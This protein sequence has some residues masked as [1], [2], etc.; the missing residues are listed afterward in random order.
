MT[1]MMT[2]EIPEQQNYVVTDVREA[3]GGVTSSNWRRILFANT[4]ATLLV[5][6]LF[7]PASRAQDGPA[8]TSRCTNADDLVSQA[9]QVTSDLKQLA[10]ADL[11]SNNP[12]KAVETIHDPQER[13]Q[14]LRLQL[15][16]CFNGESLSSTWSVGN[17]PMPLIM[18]IIST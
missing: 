17:G 3:I 2:P 9:G 12:A 13:A 16:D 15:G 6:I 7:A 1:E 8:T 10:P 18:R 14:L 5:F 11:W 4:S